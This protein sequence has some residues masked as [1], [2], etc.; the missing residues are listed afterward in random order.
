MSDAPDKVISS[1]DF[2]SRKR[3]KRYIH[4]NLVCRGIND[5]HRLSSECRIDVYVRRNSYISLTN[6]CCNHHVDQRGFLFSG[7]IE[8]LRYINRPY[9]LNGQEM[10]SFLEALRLDVDYA[11]QRR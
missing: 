11:T 7:I 3:R 4:R 5:I 9:A 10:Q 1:K 8:G 6:V 2:H